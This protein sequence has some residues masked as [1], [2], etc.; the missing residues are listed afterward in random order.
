MCA[1]PGNY[2]HVRADT[3]LQGVSGWL[4]GKEIVQTLIKPIGASRL[5][6]MHFDD[7]TVPYN[8]G[9]KFLALSRLKDLAEVLEHEP[10]IEL[11]TLPVGKQVT[12]NR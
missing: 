8:S 5:I 12:L 11:Q 3:V 4:S 10:D 7:F 6:A 2:D 9:I 1:L